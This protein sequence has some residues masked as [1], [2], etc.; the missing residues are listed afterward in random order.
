[1]KTAMRLAVSAALAGALLVAANTPAMAAWRG[2]ISH[3]MGFAFAA[4]GALKVEKGVYR[5]PLT[6]QH[7]TIVYHFADGGLDYKAIVVDLRDMA[8]DSATLIG[9]AEYNFQDNK[10]V[11]MDTFG[12]I[13]LQYG[14]RFT[15]DEPNNGGRSI[16][17]F[18]FVNGRMLRKA[19]SRP[20]RPAAITICRNSD[21]SSIS[22]TFYTVRAA[23]DAIELPPPRR[24]NRRYRCQGG[25]PQRWLVVYYCLFN[26]FFFFSNIIII[27]I[28]AISPPHA[29][30]GSRRAHAATK[31]KVYIYK[32]RGKPMSASDLGF[33][34]PSTRRGD[35]RT[36]EPSGALPPGRARPSCSSPRT[37]TSNTRSR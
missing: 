35:S 2:Y 5:S 8:N 9:E 3:P 30:A 20:C 28:A 27:I 32:A 29:A 26:I 14:R 12:R 4:P 6:G 37:T 16:A 10:K 17:A 31:K 36:R 1:M 15:I 25:I 21:G 23:D 19:C 13:D 24:N 7:S 34:S 11:M 33:S 22:I 18:Y